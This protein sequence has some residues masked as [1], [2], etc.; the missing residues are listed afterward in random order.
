MRNEKLQE[1]YCAHRPLIHFTSKKGWV[2]DPN[3]LI[4]YEGYYHLYFQ[5]YPEGVQHGP[6]HWGHA[7]TKDFLEW[8][9]LP[10]VL[11]PDEKGTIF[12]GSMVYDKEN[13]SGL[14]TKENP[15]LVAVFTQHLEEGK[16]V[17]Q[18]QSIAYSLDGGM[19][20]I[21][22]DENPVLDM[23]LR[24]FRDPKVF[25][26]APEKKWVMVTAA[27]QE[28]RFF[29]SDNLRQWKESGIFR[30][31]DM[32]PDVIWEC[33]DLVKLSDE[34]GE[35]RWVLFISQN[36]QDYVESG[37][38]Y[39]TGYFDG[40]NFYA[41]SGTKETL[42]VDFGRDNYAAATYAE[43][44]GRVI[45]QS[46]MNCWAYAGILPE[47]GFRGSMT[48]PRE[49][50]LKK[51]A[52]G[53]RILQK[54]AKEAL[55]GLRR[56]GQQVSLSSGNSAIEFI[57]GIYHFRLEKNMESI[58]FQHAGKWIEIKIDFCYGKIMLDRSH[59]GGKEY[60][61]CFQEMNWMY[62]HDLKD[63]ELYVVLDVTSLEIFAAGGE[64]VGT[65]QY[66]TER[67]L[68]NIVIGG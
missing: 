13:T 63:R 51:T 17:I 37:V 52:E 68:E 2:N 57:P 10:I 22:Y 48:L 47:A 18:Y 65:F 43:V 35:K 26:Y 5:Y 33:P 25:W 8:E 66:F 30:Q 53:Y 38:R 40:S 3:G 41:E 7:R 55:E 67:P 42:F 58:R 16:K 9:E 28:L 54:P 44:E 60:G 34:H 39:Y 49:L 59:C 15:P 56:F 19:T 50:S 21:K 61:P 23:G 14:G 20:F 11:Y 62:F 27:G 12:S 64:A 36:T 45:Q 4:F 32:K 6:M 1:M 31:E 24:D 46:W 29:C